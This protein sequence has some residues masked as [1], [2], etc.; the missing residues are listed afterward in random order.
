MSSSE[1]TPLTN[2]GNSSESMDMHNDVRSIW[3][4]RLITG[5]L[6]ASVVV[7]LMTI[8]ND[9]TTP[10][11]VIKSNINDVEPPI[12]IY[13][14]V[15]KL[16][17]NRHDV[18]IIQTSLGAPSQQYSKVEC[19]P[20]ARIIPS[21]LAPDAILQVELGA[22]A[23]P[24]RNVSILGFGGAFTEASALNFESLSKE[25]KEAVMELLYGKDGLG[26]S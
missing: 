15:C 18:E 26:Y 11:P 21:Y 23:F 7:F 22:P 13:R 17:S 8:I 3:K 6:V 25:G 2:M 1:T 12:P 10:G 5:V 9:D 4:D 16:F 20:A 19:Q 14:P 24:D